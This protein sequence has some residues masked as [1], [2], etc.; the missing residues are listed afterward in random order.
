MG[1]VAK[2]MTNF[3][4]DNKGEA[5]SDYVKQLVGNKILKHMENGNNSVII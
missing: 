1:A 4:L 3:G 5:V 2:H